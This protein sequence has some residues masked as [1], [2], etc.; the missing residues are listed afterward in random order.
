MGRIENLP[1]PIGVWEKKRLL[2][3]ADRI[4]KSRAAMNMDP[5]E[6]ERLEVNSLMHPPF[7]H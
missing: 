1:E 7:A 5:E 2:V 3:A 6:V 4:R